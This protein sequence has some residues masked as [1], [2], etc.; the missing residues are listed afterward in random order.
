MDLEIVRAT[1]HVFTTA[2]NTRVVLRMDCEN[3]EVY[4]ECQQKD[5]YPIWV[6]FQRSVQ[7]S[8]PNLKM[9]AANALLDELA[10]EFQTILDGYSTRVDAQTRINGVFSDDAEKSISKIRERC[11]EI[12]NQDHAVFHIWEPWD[13]LGPIGSEKMQCRS[14]GI[15]RKTTKK[16]L[17]KIAEDIL[18]EENVDFVNGL[19]KYLES[20]R[21]FAKFNNL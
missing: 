3:G 13:L 1:D 2:S 8:V 18:C 11:E 19:E 5:H 14:L 20:L 15:S 21:D 7:F 17:A 4:F 12:K 9:D 16:Q 10:E 6:G